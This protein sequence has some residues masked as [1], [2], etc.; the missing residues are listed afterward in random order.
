[1]SVDI[2]SRKFMSEEQRDVKNIF[3]GHSKSDRWRTTAPSFPT[4]SIT[5]SIWLQINLT[6]ST[7]LTTAVR[8]EFCKP[9]RH[10]KRVIKC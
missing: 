5:F 8:F 2:L 10:A 1:M 3:K 6:S 4:L 9:N 7:L